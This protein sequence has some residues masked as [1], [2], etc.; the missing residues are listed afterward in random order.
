[1]T[2]RFILDSNEDYAR[3]KYQELEWKHNHLGGGEDTYYS[4]YLDEM[5][6][7]YPIF[8][9]GKVS[10][11]MELLETNPKSSHF[12]QKKYDEFWAETNRDYES[13]HPLKI[14]KKRG[15]CLLFWL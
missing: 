2:D 12:N 11:L 13:R 7:L 9:D 14:E 3:K 4:I 6:D 5:V 10:P 1:M 8:N 15:C